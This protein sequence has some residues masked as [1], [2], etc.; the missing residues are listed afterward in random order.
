MVIAFSTLNFMGIHLLARYS[1]DGF[2]HKRLTKETKNYTEGGMR[3]L[4]S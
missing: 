2:L 1:H 4:N 3:D